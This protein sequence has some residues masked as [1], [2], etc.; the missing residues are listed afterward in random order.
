M[1]ELFFASLITTGNGSV[2]FRNKTS[3]L[4]KNSVAHSFMAREALPVLSS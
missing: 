4:E 2:F 3:L 1:S